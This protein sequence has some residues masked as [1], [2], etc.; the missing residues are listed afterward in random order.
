MARFLHEI[1]AGDRRNEPPDISHHIHHAGQSADGIAAHVHARRPRAGQ[2]DVVAEGHQ[3]NGR[4]GIKRVRHLG[5]HDQQAR[6][7]QR[8]RRAQTA[9]RD[10]YIAKPAAQHGR[11]PAREQRTAGAEQQRRSRQQRALFHV[12]AVSLKQVSGKPGD[13]KIK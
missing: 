13:E 3:C 12:E 2:L 6:S 1:A 4:H 7:A 9:A 5:H 8:A 10:A 11:N